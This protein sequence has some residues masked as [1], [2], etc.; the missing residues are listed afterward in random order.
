MGRIHECASETVR[1]IL[2]PVLREDNISRSIRYDKLLITYANKLC[3]KYSHQHQQD[4][5][6]AKLRL[7]GRVL[8][9]VKKYN[10]NVT[11]FSD[12]Y[13]P[14]I[15]DDCLK[16]V[17]EVAYFD[18]NN[19]KYGAPTVASNIGTSLKHV[20]NLLI[21]EC[22]KTND[23]KKQDSTENF[24]KILQEDCGTSI[25]KIVE[26]NMTQHKRQKK[27]SLPS[28]DD[29]KMLH[30]Y[31]KNER[32][33]LYT[34]LQKKFTYKTWQELAKVTLTST[35]VFNRRRAGEIERITIEDFNTREGIT[36]ETCLDLY[37]SL[38]TNLQKVYIIF[39][40]NV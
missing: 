23:T 24:L 13:D 26:E 9:A 11:E 32:K 14:S 33:L 20:G 25:N 28:M 8:I 16:A 19:K 3:I 35:Q 7:L 12:I 39:S 18:C 29:I 22:I 4:M 40:V 17:N 30:S 37:K 5:I 6:R 2:F 31:L 34:K 15:Y 27:V 1:K 36:R 10:P 21:T 38:G